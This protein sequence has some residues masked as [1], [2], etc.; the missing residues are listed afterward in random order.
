MNILPLKLSNSSNITRNKCETFY[1]TCFMTRAFNL[2]TS[3]FQDCDSM[4]IKTISTSMELLFQGT[5]N[6]CGHGHRQEHGIVG[7]QGQLRGY[8]RWTQNMLLL[9]KMNKLTK[10]ISGGCQWCQ[11]K[12]NA[13]ELKLKERLKTL[14]NGTRDKSGFTILNWAKLLGNWWLRPSP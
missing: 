1:Q 11:S 10:C 14:A 7:F 9:S 3:N 4:W 6:V 5:G 12:C 8:F 2:L 13:K